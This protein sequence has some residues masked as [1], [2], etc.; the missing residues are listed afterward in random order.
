MHFV[1]SV[2]DFSFDNLIACE[3]RPL[4]KEWN[5]TFKNGV[6]MTAGLLINVMMEN[7]GRNHALRAD[8]L[9]C[10]LWLIQTS[11]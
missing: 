10:N 11:R 8:T 3:A 7:V 5:I 9:D 2:R 6:L 4:V 1:S